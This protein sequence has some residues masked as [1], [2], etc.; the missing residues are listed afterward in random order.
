MFIAEPVFWGKDETGNE[1]TI[2]GYL[3]FPQTTHNNLCVSIYQAV[4]TRTLGILPPDNFKLDPIDRLTAFVLQKIYIAEV[5][6]PAVDLTETRVPL[7]SVL[8]S[9][10][11]LRGAL[12]SSFDLHFFIHGSSPLPE[13]KPALLFWLSEDH[14]KITSS[15]NKLARIGKTATIAPEGWKSFEVPH[16][17][18]DEKCIGART[19]QATYQDWQSLRPVIFKAGHWSYEGHHDFFTVNISLAVEYAFIEKNELARFLVGRILPFIGISQEHID[20]NWHRIFENQPC[21]NSCQVNTTTN[22]GLLVYRSHPSSDLII[23][24]LLDI[25]TPA[26]RELALSRIFPIL[27]VRMRWSNSTLLIPP[28]VREDIRKALNSGRETPSVL[29]FDDAAITGRTL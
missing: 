6:N 22:H 16:F 12:E 5:Y 7:G 11:T 4:L 10:S 27:P 29:L 21:N 17:N 18:I 24:T 19:P 1:I 3:D 26:G 9:G 23:H 25:L 15:S 20:E 8:V 2:A 14:I 13:K 28:L